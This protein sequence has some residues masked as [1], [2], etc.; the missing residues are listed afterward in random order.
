MNADHNKS[1]M[2]NSFEPFIGAKAGSYVDNQEIDKK[3]ENS[4]GLPNRV[5]EQ[6]QKPSLLKLEKLQEI[7]KSVSTN[8][9]QR[10]NFFKKTV[11]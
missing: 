6:L 11:Y 7:N 4:I 9:R 3:E 1:S 10:S 8:V 2:S 5:Q